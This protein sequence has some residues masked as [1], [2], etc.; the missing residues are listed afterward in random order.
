MLSR[1]SV[2][3]AA[4]AMAPGDADFVSRVRALDDA[5]R[6]RGITLTFQT[7]MRLFRE[8]FL[9]LNDPRAHLSPLLDASVAD[10]AEARWILGQ[11]ADGQV[12]TT[13]AFR[14]YPDD[15]TTSYDRWLTLRM[16]YDRPEEAAGPEEACVLTGEA[17]EANRRLRCWLASG[18]TWVHA[19]HRGPDRDGIHLSEL[20]P[21]LSR[22]LGMRQYPEA[23]ATTSGIRPKLASAGVAERYGYKKIAPLLVHTRDRQPADFLFLW[24]PRGEMEADARTFHQRLTAGRDVR[25]AG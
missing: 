13:Q 7:D 15:G 16:F 21:R 2:V 9:N 5:C 3:D 8:V 18:G 14:F 25:A 24:M 17:A 6:R 1:L 22:T 20:L 11:D 23:E 19:D 12:V 4:S 10:L